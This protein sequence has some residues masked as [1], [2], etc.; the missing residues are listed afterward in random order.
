MDSFAKLATGI[1]EYGRM[2]LF[3][4]EKKKWQINYP[5]R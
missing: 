4:Q 5:A 3:K 1:L 2:V